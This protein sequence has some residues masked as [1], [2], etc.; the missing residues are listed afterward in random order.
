MRE[1]RRG[2]TSGLGVVL[3]EMF[4][5]RKR[6]EIGLIYCSL[7]IQ[8]KQLVSSHPG[9]LYIFWNSVVD[10]NPGNECEARST[11]ETIITKQVG[12][13]DGAKS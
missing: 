13:D 3:K 9:Y 7:Y 1:G 4:K 2:E 11:R 6:L 12:P 5:V 8:A 10:L